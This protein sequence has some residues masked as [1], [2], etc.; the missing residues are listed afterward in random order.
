[1]YVSIWITWLLLLCRKMRGPGENN[2][3]QKHKNNKETHSPTGAP[4]ENEKK[5]TTETPAIPYRSIY[6]SHI[7]RITCYDHCAYGRTDR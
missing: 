3:K 4:Y 1:M 2:N 7:D 6:V 5:T